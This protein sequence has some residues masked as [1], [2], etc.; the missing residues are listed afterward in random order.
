MLLGVNIDHV[1]TLRQARQ[2]IEPDPVLAAFAAQNAGA[3]SIVIHLREDRRHIQDRDLKVLR[4][5]V[6]IKLNL[7]MSVAEEIVGIACTVKPDQATLVPEKRQEVTTEG[8]LDVAANPAK[9]KKAVDKLAA[10]GIA[11]SLFI[12]PEKRQIDAAVKSGAGMIELHTGRYSGARNKAQEDRFFIQLA[13]AAKY[14]AKKGLQVFAGHGLN[15]QNVRRICTI[16][17]IEELNIGHTIISRAI[18]VG[19]EKAVREMKGIIN[20]R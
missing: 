17:E 12:D 15:Y 2:G 20:S 9:I 10:N 7:E 4:Q 6:K 8:G 3:D 5:A 14:A 18:F 11:V 1:A 19:M 13:G 16:P